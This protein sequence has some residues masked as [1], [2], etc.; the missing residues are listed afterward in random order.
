VKNELSV[1]REETKKALSSKDDEIKLL[2]V[3]KQN[4]ETELK[5]THSSNVLQL[6]EKQTLVIE[7]EKQIRLLREENSAVRQPIIVQS[8]PSIPE[9]VLNDKNRQITTLQSTVDL[10]NSEVEEWKLKFNQLD[11]LRN[12]RSHVIL[13]SAIHHNQCSP[14]DQKEG[15]IKVLRARLDAEREEINVLRSQLQLSKKKEDDVRREAFKE[16][17]KL[18]IEMAFKDHEMKNLLMEY[19]KLLEPPGTPERSDEDSD[20]AV[21]PKKRKLMK[22]GTPVTKK[23][24]KRL[25]VNEEEDEFMDL[26][27]APKSFELKTGPQGLVKITMEPL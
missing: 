12:D 26:M 18:K 19:N 4:L 7:L 21:T 3:Q 2:V 25:I 5:N 9:S 10:L 23:M 1:V 27:D 22:N 11:Q 13:N 6:A 24:P 15:E 17:E 14:L 20:E 16:V 8:T